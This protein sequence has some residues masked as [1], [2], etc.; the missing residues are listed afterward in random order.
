MQL[1]LPGWAGVLHVVQA[2]VHGV[3]DAGACHVHG[4]RA[5]VCAGGGARLHVRA[6]VLGARH[7]V[8]VLWV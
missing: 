5:G 8:I 4:M 3:R 1:V 2:G 7:H 6:G